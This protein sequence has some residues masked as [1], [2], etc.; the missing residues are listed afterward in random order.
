MMFCGKKKGGETDYS[1][2]SWDCFVK[3]CAAL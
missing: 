1:F 2:A 3:L